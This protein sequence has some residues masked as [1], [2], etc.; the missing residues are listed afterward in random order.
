[1][2]ALIIAAGQNVKRLL[3]AKGARLSP[4]PG[5]GLFAVSVGVG[6]APH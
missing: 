4:W 6:I 3:Q 2:E 5:A 1:M